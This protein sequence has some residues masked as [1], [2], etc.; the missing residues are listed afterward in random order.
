V[1]C[2]D[3]RGARRQAIIDDNDDASGGI[4]GRAQA[5]VERIPP[6]TPEGAEHVHGAVL[7]HYMTGK[8]ALDLHPDDIYWC[9]ADPGWVTGTSYG[10]IAPLLHG[11]TSIVDEAD[12]DAE[13]WYRILQDEQV[14]VWYNR[15]H[16]PA[17]ANEER[18]GPGKTFSF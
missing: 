12:F 9:T 18:H 4:Q 11:V 2:C 10:I 16:G 3:H 6:G 17:H 8:Y 1:L 5:R 15:A 7:M 14:S 13:R